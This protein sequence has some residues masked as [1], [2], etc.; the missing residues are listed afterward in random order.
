M[1]QFSSRFGIPG[2]LILISMPR[3]TAVLTDLETT[4]GKKDNRRSPKMKRIRAQKRK[5]A[6]IVKRMVAGKAAA[7]STKVAAKTTKK[8]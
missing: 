2:N 4:M 1:L 3:R 8:K 6:S 5:K 7:A